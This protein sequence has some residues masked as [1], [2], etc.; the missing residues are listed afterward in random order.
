LLDGV[1]PPLYEAEHWRRRAEEMR[2]IASDMA[3]LPRAQDALP[4]IAQQL[5][6]RDAERIKRDE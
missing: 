3:S 6:V 5:T 4:R 2:K 1:T